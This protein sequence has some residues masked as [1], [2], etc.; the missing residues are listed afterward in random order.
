MD[1]EGRRLRNAAPVMHPNGSANLF[2]HLDGYTDEW[3]LIAHTPDALP[4]N[5]SSSYQSLSVAESSS[6]RE[7]DHKIR[8]LGLMG[9]QI[10]AKVEGFGFCFLVNLLPWCTH[11]HLMVIRMIV[12][13]R[14]LKRRRLGTWFDSLI[15][16]SLLRYGEE[17]YRLLYPPNR[18]ASFD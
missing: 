7:E 16:C 2:I 12:M 1:R 8:S 11:T 15:F 18:C 4:N 10:K 6:N 9:Y 5:L 14:R 13:A 17:D 3:R